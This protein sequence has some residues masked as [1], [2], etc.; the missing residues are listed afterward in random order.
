MPVLSRSME[1]GGTV[2]GGVQHLQGSLCPVRVIVLHSLVVLF[3]LYLM[4][5]HGLPSVL[6]LLGFPGEGRAQV[7]LADL[8]CDYVRSE[9][10]ISVFVTSTTQRSV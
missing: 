6:W 8:P 9:W 5:E 3:F 10:S 1:L 2:G 7:S 4:V